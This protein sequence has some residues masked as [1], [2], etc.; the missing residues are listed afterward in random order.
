MNN[1]NS[2]TKVKSHNIWLI[3]TAVFKV[4]I[5]SRAKSSNTMGSTALTTA[6]TAEAPFQNQEQLS[7][8]H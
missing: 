3:L 5:L 7:Q 8:S 4:S 6:R 1:I 2:N